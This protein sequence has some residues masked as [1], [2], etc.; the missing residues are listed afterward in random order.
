MRVL[1]NWK[2]SRILLSAVLFVFA[3]LAC[4][5]CQTGPPPSAKTP[6]WKTALDTKA[7]PA[8]G[9]AAPRNFHANNLT[10]GV[11]YEF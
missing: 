2:A 5:L 4:A 9:F 11:H 7:G 1:G 10:A 8:D 3:S 6:H